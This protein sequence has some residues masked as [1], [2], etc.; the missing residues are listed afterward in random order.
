MPPTDPTEYAL[1]E[2]ARHTGT[3]AGRASA[4]SR[5]LDDWDSEALNAAVEAERLY[6][7][8]HNIRH[9]LPGEEVAE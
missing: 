6:L 7:E 5:G 9:I 8:R 4:T 3:E 2:M 1:R